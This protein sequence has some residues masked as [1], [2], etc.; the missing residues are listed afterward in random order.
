MESIIQRN[1]LT[2]Q[3]AQKKNVLVLFLLSPFLI[4]MILLRLPLLIGLLGSIREP[5]EDELLEQ[6][7]DLYVAA[8]RKYLAVLTDDQA[9][10]LRN[11]YVA[12]VRAKRHF[13]TRK[14]QVFFAENGP[15][16]QLIDKLHSDQK[17]SSSEVCKD[18]V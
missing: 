16:N 7:A 12:D 3:M 5:S 1:D 2:Y 9:N 17:C 8:L 15:S 18:K 10:T 13:E 11:V 4:L 6:S 14:S